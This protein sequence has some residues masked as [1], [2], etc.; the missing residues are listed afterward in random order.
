MWTYQYDIEISNYDQLRSNSDYFVFGFIY[1]ITYTDGTHYFGK[2]NI[3][4][5]VKLPELKS[6]EQRP[7]SQR[8]GKNVK[9]KRVYFDVLTKETDWL[10]YTGSSEK[11]EGLEI[12]NKQILA[13]A[14]S[15]RELTY[16]EAKCLFWENAIEDPDCHNSSILNLFFRDNLK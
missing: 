7:N 15:K 2:K 13:L 1:K 6:G 4:K 8:V 16:L 9:G 14:E 3:F 11:T 12:L 10:T 5:K